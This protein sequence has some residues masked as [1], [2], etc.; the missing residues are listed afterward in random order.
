MLMFDKDTTVVPKTSG[1]FST[2]P[3][4]NSTQL[5]RHPDSEVVPLRQSSIYTE[6]KIGLKA[7]DKR[8]GLVMERECVARFPLDP[9]RH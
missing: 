4:A 3:L 7:L 8:G 1:W 5:A 2:Y 6:D 9:S